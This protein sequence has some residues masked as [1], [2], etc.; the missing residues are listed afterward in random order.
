MSLVPSA[1]RYS[2]FNRLANHGYLPRNG[3]ELSIPMILDAASGGHS[4]A[5]LR[6]GLTSFPSTEVFNM[7]PDTILGAAKL[8]LLSG[9]DPTTLDLEALKLQV[10]VRTGLE[11]IPN[12]LQAQPDRE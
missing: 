12:I 6:S 11:S 3:K 1:G 9:P 7:A 2:S 10:P 5:R 4:T 8:G